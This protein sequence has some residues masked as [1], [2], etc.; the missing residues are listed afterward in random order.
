MQADAPN[1][2]ATTCGMGSGMQ[3]HASVV[4]G[5]AQASPKSAAQA[6][7][8]LVGIGVELQEVD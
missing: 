3:V 2:R 8:P 5:A 4:A 7:T 1:E 6:L